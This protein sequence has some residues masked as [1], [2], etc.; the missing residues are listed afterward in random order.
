[1]Y[2][3]F[4]IHNIGNKFHV[5]SVERFDI[6]FSGLVAFKHVYRARDVS[7]ER[8]FV[9][10]FYQVSQGV[11]FITFYGVLCV[12]RT[13]YYNGGLVFGS[14]QLCCFQPVGPGHVDIE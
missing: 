13:K 7:R 4:E 11:D 2:L 5:H 6:K 10:G 9:Y 1:M 12:M 3:H 14:Y 8:V